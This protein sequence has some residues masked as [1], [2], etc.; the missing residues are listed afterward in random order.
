MK[1]KIDSSQLKKVA[2]NAKLAKAHLEDRSRLHRTMQNYQAKQW[3]RN[4]YGGHVYG[5][6]KGL[7]NFTKRIRIWRGYSPGPI[8]YE[9][10]TLH[11]WVQEQA[12][13]PHTMISAS[14]SS[15][16]WT[17]TFTGGTDG[18][19]AVLHDQGYM[20]GGM[21]IRPVP[22]RVIF[23]MSEEDIEH[24]VQLAE[25]YSLEQVGILES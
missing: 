2:Q 18:S 4:L 3:R 15:T 17:P 22:P 14:L 5:R 10:G 9:T 1:I 13:N 21:V 20:S 11:G 6:W 8:M 24:H 19:Y 12:E 25:R 16:T 23:D 7:T